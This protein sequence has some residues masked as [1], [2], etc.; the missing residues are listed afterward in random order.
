MSLPREW[1]LQVDG[2]LA[3]RLPDDVTHFQSTYL[4]NC[5]LYF[6]PLSAAAARASRPRFGSETR[7]RTIPAGHSLTCHRCCSKRY[8]RH[9][10]ATS[11]SFRHLLRQ[12]RS[13]PPS[14][15]SSRA[16]RARSSPTLHCSPS[17]TQ[18]DHYSRFTRHHQFRSPIWVRTVFES[19]IKAIYQVVW[20]EWIH[21]VGQHRWQSNHSKISRQKQLPHFHC[22]V[23]KRMKMTMKIYWPSQV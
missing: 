21:R 1:S 10:L 17:T 15:T 3:M 5:M 22:Q 14:T 16:S 11:T 23:A 2:W 8:S 19:M 13:H 9:C 20:P 4:L 6:T 18:P 7:N 12:L